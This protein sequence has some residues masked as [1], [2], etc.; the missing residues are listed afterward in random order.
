MKDPLELQGNERELF[1]AVGR[2]MAGA[3]HQM[4]WGIALNLILNSIRQTTARRETAE[5]ILNEL[6]GR[7]KNIL[8]DLHYDSVTG[9]R[10]GVIPHTQVIQMPFHDEGNVIFHGK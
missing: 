7:G 4:V 5:A 6:F 1:E 9:L 10:R 2:V 3:P 8:L